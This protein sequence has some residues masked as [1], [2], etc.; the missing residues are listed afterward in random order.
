MP[1]KSKVITVPSQQIYTPISPSMEELLNSRSQVLENWFY[2]MTGKFFGTFF[3]HILQ[4]SGPKELLKSIANY[5]E[6]VHKNA[7]LLGEEPVYVEQPLAQA[8]VVNTIMA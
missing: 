2:R 8:P 5:Q 1:V 3:V 7:Y 4:Q 6:F